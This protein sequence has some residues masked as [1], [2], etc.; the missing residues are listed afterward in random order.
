MNAPAWI[1]ET[2][3]NDAQITAAIG[4]RIYRD[5]APEAASYPFI[6]IQPLQAF[7]VENA[8]SDV[9]M[10]SERWQ[11]KVTDK[12]TS[13]AAIRAIAS[14]IR[15]LLHKQ[16]ATGI[17]SSTFASRL[18]YPE[19]SETGAK[20]SNVVQDFRIYTQEVTNG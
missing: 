18:E 13:Y 17:I 14:R 10:D 3:K 1:F 20:F 7:P 9:I 2:L 5:V 8:Y 15:A 12:G 6:V 16:R 19:I 4:T 11:V